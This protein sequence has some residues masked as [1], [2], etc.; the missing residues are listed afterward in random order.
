MKPGAKMALRVA[1]N[2]LKYRKFMRLI[3]YFYPVVAATLIFGS[4]TLGFAHSFKLGAIQIGHPAAP[5]SLPGQTS[6]VVYLT[7]DNQGRVADR[8]IK[9]D[10]PIAQNVMVHQMAMNGSVMTMRE[11]DDLPLKPMTKLV[12]TAGS[13]YHVMMTGLKQPLVAQDKIPLTLTFERA[14]TVEVIVN[15]ERNAAQKA[16]DKASG[17]TEGKEPPMN[18]N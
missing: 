8:L 13:S 14:G 11:M 6:A 15:V 17:A 12:L 4:Q 10:S 5:A 16:A 3:K 2:L 1:I 9:L 18:H 7:I